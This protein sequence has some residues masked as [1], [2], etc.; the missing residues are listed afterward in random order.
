MAKGR[1]LFQREIDDK[2][3]Q[4]FNNQRPVRE[5]ILDWI[6][7]LTQY[8]QQRYGGNVRIFIKGGS[9]LNLLRE[10]RSK[11]FGT[12]KTWSDF[13]N[14]IIINPNLP[15][16]QWYDIHRQ[17]HTYLKEEYLP[18]FQKEWDLFLSYNRKEFSAEQQK[19]LDHFKAETIN[20]AILDFPRYQF[21][22]EKELSGNTKSCKVDTAYQ[23]NA[24]L[25]D[26]REALNL[27]LENTSQSNMVFSAGM[28][29][30]HPL[31]HFDTAMS[32]ANIADLEERKNS[33]IKGL[34]KKLADEGINNDALFFN[35]YFPPTSMVLDDSVSSNEAP[36]S[37]SI[38][39]N[40]TISKFYLYRIIVRYANH[41]FFNDGERKSFGKRD[42]FSPEQKAFDRGLRAKFRGE[43]IDVSIPRRDSEEA[44]Q[45]W[46]QVNT[47]T[48]QYFALPDC[49]IKKEP[50]KEQDLLLKG[51]RGYWLNVPGWDYQLNEN[52]LLILEVFIDIS[53]SPHKFWKRVQRVTKAVQNIYGSDESAKS[54]EGLRFDNIKALFDGMTSEPKLDFMR[55]LIQD[56][57]GL[58]L[59]DYSCKYLQP[60]SEKL[61]DKLF[62][63]DFKKIDS[64]FEKDLSTQV[65]ASWNN[66]IKGKTVNGKTFEAI[67][68]EKVPE[69]TERENCQ[70]MLGFM[71]I[72]K[73][74]HDSFKSSIQFKDDDAPGNQ[75]IKYLNQFRAKVENA[76]EAPC[77]FGGIL[78]SYIDTSLKSAATN[79]LDYYLPFVEL[80]I[81][82]PESFNEK[83]LVKKLSDI[84]LIKESD[85]AFVDDNS[86][87]LLD[88]SQDGYVKI[89]LKKYNLPILLWVVH[90]PTETLTKFQEKLA[91]LAQVGNSINQKTVELTHL[92]QGLNTRYASLED[93]ERLERSEQLAQ[94]EKALA[95]KIAEQR[96]LRRQSQLMQIFN[97]DSTQ[98]RGRRKSDNFRFL[99]GPEAVKHMDIR[100]ANGKSFYMTH[101]LD[102]V[103]THY[104]DF[105]TRF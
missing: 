100:I 6:A 38:L 58:L 35:S 53:G 84:D 56:V 96:K 23:V 93:K 70:K 50:D 72:Y 51:H 34:R 49:D 4:E 55:P 41:D 52:I 94:V 12:T 19:G 54:N 68:Q 31:N 10:Y 82:A 26:D 28:E 22:L 90:T 57:N 99:K 76:V 83:T 20:N 60:G 47:H 80:F 88:D 78:S 92:Q 89:I 69:T 73:K 62:G 17:I 11:Q 5:F 45:Q 102:H 15:I 3:T 36:N 74:L 39:L 44:I 87:S 33:D 43:L 27:T 64:L 81:V 25:K 8:L 42:W 59:D 1:T 75:D 66:E 63:F 30:M 37:S 16:A 18:C 67:L 29:L 71:L 13:D 7:Q 98:L 97:P 79:P 32:L 40:A 2:L 21:Q 14:Q 86:Y 95:E 104:K 91:V 65:M 103:R 105:I 46:Q 77:T 101:W 85:E 24:P 48:V 61:I 9:A